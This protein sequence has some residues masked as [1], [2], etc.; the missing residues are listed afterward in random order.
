MT[1]MFILKCA[2]KLVPKKYPINYSISVLKSLRTLRKTDG[3]VAVTRPI[4]RRCRI[5]DIQS[6]VK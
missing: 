2:L 5:R 1:Y 3:V 6:V 4:I